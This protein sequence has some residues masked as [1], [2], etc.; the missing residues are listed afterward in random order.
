[1]A[2]EGTGEILLLVIFCLKTIEEQFESKIVSIFLHA[3]VCPG[4]HSATAS[5]L[6]CILVPESEIGGFTQPG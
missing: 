1:M 5:Y 2:S 4:I 3:Y 6:V